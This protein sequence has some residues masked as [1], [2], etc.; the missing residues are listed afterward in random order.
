MIQLMTG[1]YAHSYHHYSFMHYFIMSLIHYLGYHLG[2]ELSRSFGLPYWIGGMIISSL[3]YAVY[4]KN[5]KRPR[6]RRRYRK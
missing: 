3:I 6:K 2:G 4:K 1:Y 5:N